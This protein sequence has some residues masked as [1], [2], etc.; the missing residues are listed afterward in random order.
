MDTD[1]PSVILKLK[2]GGKVSGHKKMGGKEE[3]T[4][5]VKKAMGGGLGAMPPVAMGA[6]SI[7][8]SAM[9]PSAMAPKRPALSLR[10]R[11]MRGRAMPPM[12][13]Q[14]PM[15]SQGPM[16]KGGKAMKK[17]STGGVQ[18]GNGGGFKK[19]GSATSEITTG[20]YAKTEIHQGKRDNAKAK[21]GD[22][23]LGN[24][25]GFKKGGMTKSTC[26]KDGGVA[27]SE[28]STGDY[29]KTRVDE[30]KRDN[31]SAKTGD[32]KI[33]NGGGYKKGGATKKFASG[34]SAVAMPQGSKKAP[35]PVAINMLSGTYKKGG[36]VKKF[37]DGD[38]VEGDA[39]QQANTRGYN[40]TL[41]NEKAENEADAKAVRSALMYI[42]NEL[43]KIGTAIYEKAKS[44]V[45]P[46]TSKK[47]GGRC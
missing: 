28:M 33:G 45:K 11:A 2:K 6:P 1:E 44:V 10:N 34:G 42:P 5:A 31:A 14:G 39:M 36:K 9:P 3:N 15:V 23:K 22:V 12:A 29:S 46:T 37:K 19:G 41:A 27:T 13:P 4:K 32:V 30:A 25:G 8:G 47:R 17:C 43:G 20:D 40:A 7:A 21:T 18:N 38:S 24:A 26:M 16:K 35:P